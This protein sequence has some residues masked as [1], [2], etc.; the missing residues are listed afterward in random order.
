MCVLKDDHSV[1]GVCVCVFVCGSL[2]YNACGK[3]LRE[4]RVF[5]GFWIGC[6]WRVFGVRKFICGFL[7]S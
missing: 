4:L 5:P 7:I 6:D 1:F 3:V 2:T